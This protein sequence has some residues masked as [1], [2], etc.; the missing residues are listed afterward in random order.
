MEKSYF[1]APTECPICGESLQEDSVFLMCYNVDCKGRKLGDLSKWINKLDLKGID[2]A[3]IEKLF[4]GGLIETPSDF[5]KLKPELI[6]ELD[7]FKS[8]SANKIVDL[9]NSKKKLTLSEFIGGL[10][11]SNF[12]GKTAEL[13]EENGY[14]TPGKIMAATPADLLE[15]KGIGEITANEIVYGINKKQLEIFKL[16]EQGIELEIKEPKEDK[17][18]SM[19]DGKSFLITGTLSTPRKEFEKMITD[20]GGFIKG[21]VSKNLDYLIVGENAGSK[22]VKA[23]KIESIK[24]ITEQDFMEMIN[25]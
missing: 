23:Q 2:K 8:R 10:N 18:E 22:L 5:Y 7:G 3:T 1:E 21:S 11:I 14:N 4:D 25:G 6:C 15:I 12:S 19:L 24:I 17:G 16:F 13:L 20:N 9:I